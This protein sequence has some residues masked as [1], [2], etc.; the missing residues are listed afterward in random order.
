M[1]QSGAI[2]SDRITPVTGSLSILDVAAARG[3]GRSDD[4]YA[5]Y[6]C[7]PGA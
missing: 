5:N 6:G 1:G 7:G 3:A 4:F 2:G